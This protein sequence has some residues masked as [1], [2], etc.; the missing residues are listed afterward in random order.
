[1]VDAADAV[2]FITD[3]P[4]CLG[5]FMQYNHPT[6]YHQHLPYG[7]S[8]PM[9]NILLDMYKLCTIQN[10]MY[11]IF[12]LFFSYT[13]YPKGILK[14]MAIMEM[15]INKL[16]FKSIEINERPLRKY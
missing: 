6:K 2:K 10:L 11:A 14:K 12:F 9:E 13:H 16:K 1:M 15:M 4:I 3:R 5:K 8:L 7:Q